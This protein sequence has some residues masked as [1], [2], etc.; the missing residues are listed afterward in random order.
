[1]FIFNGK[2]DVTMLML[3]AVRL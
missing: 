3:T 1:V 2:H